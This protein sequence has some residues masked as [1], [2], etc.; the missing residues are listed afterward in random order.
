ML[1]WEVSSSFS[2]FAVFTDFI[3]FA[4]FAADTSVAA[5][6]DFIFSWFLC[7]HC[8][9]YFLWGC[10]FI[11]YCLGVGISFTLCDYLSIFLI[12]LLFYI[13]FLWL[14]GSVFAVITASKFVVDFSVLWRDDSDSFDGFSASHSV[15][16]SISYTSVADLVTFYDFS[17]CVFRSFVV[18]GLFR[19]EVFLCVC[20]I[21]NCCS[22]FFCHK[23]FCV[24]TGVVTTVDASAGFTAFMFSV[25]SFIFC[26][27]HCFKTVLKPP[28]IC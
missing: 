7:S 14:G 9:W 1:W 15:A 20:C 26:S 16:A 18:F 25:G 12:L 21:S 17:V 3:Y 22:F 4:V 28:S 19:R 23:C 11:I 24:L 13:L 27:C 8:F 2:A 5:V 10:Y 6:C